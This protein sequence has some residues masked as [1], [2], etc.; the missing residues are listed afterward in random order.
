[1]G[2]TGGLFTWMVSVVTA[3][4]VIDGSGGHYIWYHVWSG[5]TNS[6]GIDGLERPHPMSD[7]LTCLVQ[8]KH[9]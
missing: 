1:M 5:G 2:L 3:Y 8:Y 6:S 9:T 4:I 7:I